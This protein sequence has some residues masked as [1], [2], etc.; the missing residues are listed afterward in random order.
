MEQ[1]KQANEKKNQVILIENNLISPKIL[2]PVI[3][4]PSLVYC[5]E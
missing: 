4:I 2:L 1:N 5:R 3:R